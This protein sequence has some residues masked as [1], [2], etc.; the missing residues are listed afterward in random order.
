MQLFDDLKT[1][2]DATHSLNPLVIDSDL[3]NDGKST[4]VLLIHEGEPVGERTGVG[5]AT[6]HLRRW[7]F[8]IE[9]RAATQA[10]VEVCV[11]ETNRVIETKTVTNGL[12]EIVGFPKIIKRVGVKAMAITGYEDKMVDIAVTF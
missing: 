11:I 4:Y 5:K 10:L 7:P 2:I 8:V 1:E 6:V 9:V 12:W 3:Q